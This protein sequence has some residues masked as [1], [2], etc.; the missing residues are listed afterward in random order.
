MCK[1]NCVN[2]LNY[3]I[4]YL[5]SGAKKKNKKHEKYT[6]RRKDRSVLY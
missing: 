1:T 3:R 5:F 4:G 2:Y 6:N